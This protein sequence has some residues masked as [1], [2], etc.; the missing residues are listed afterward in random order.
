MLRR[1]LESASETP[2]LDAQIILAHILGIKR[3]WVLA[4][5]EAVL[6]PQQEQSLN[7]NLR[8]L[9]SGE[10]L[11]YVL[12]HWEFYGLDF[13]VGPAVLI[14]RPETEL[15]VEQALAWLRSHPARAER[16]AVDVGSGSG[17]IAISLAAHTPDLRVI[18]ADVS[19]SAL[20]IA[21]QNAHRHGVAGQIDFCQADLLPQAAGQPF[22]LI[23]ANLPYIPSDRLAQLRVAHWEPQLAL[24]GGV[25]GLGLI[26]RLLQQASLYLAAKGLMLLEIDGSQG[27]ATAQLASVAFPDAG[28]SVL[29]DLAGL[30]RLVRVNLAAADQI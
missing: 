20:E 16:L 3:A 1:R 7:E 23:C 29:K 14:P 25:D 11:P 27:Q 18:A 6:S 19:S 22:D 26:R 30:D 2:S 8:R 15:L 5:P 28:V 13:V 12:G 4:H 10:P 9:E 17:C 21:R 24:D